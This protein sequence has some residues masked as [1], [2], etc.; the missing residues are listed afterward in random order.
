MTKNA[1]SFSPRLSSLPMFLTVTVGFILACTLS[2]VAAERASGDRPN[3]LW[4]TCE[5][6]SPHLGCYGAP[7]AITPHLDRLAQQGTRYTHAFSISGVCAPSRSCI[8]TGMY[9]TSIGSQ[10]MRCRA[11]LPKTIR[12]FTEYLREAGYYCT[13][14]RKTDYNFAHPKSAWDESSNTAHWRNRGAGQPF[15]SVF[16]MTVTHESRVRADDDQHAKNTTSLTASQRQDPSKLTLPPYYPVTPKV[17]KDWAHYFE[18]ITAMDHQAGE[19]LD[20]LENDGFAENT[21]VFYYSDHG[22]GL[23]RAKRWLYDSG[24]H[25]PMIVRWPGH[26]EAAAVE[27]RLVSFVDLAPT[28][29]SIAGI[30]IPEHLQGL[31][32]LGP[33]AGKPRRY[34]YAAR[35]RMDERYD[36]IRAVR[37]H[38]YKY[39]RNYQ[40]FKTRAQ[41]LAYAEVGSTM[42]ELRRLHQQ[43]EL[44]AVQQIFMRPTKPVEE[45]YDLQADPHEIVNLAGS[46]EH[47]EVI[48]R[49]RA[50]HESWMDRTLDTGLLPETE[51]ERLAGS[52]GIYA[53]VR[54]EKTAFPVRKLRDAALFA[55][56][57]QKTISA[58]S[59]ALHDEDPTI[60]YW[61]VTGMSTLERLDRHGREALNRVLKDDSPSV[62][63]VAAGALYRLGEREPA[64][65]VL[66]DAI[67]DERVCVRVLAANVIDG[68]IT[69]AGAT[70]LGKT[71]QTELARAAEDDDRNVKKLVS[72]TL[73]VL[74]DSTGSSN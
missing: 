1:C 46:R 69:D 12:C 11:V 70:E 67:G 71:L 24:L 7:R 19:I 50:E 58:L 66:R 9:P 40:P 47:R 22:V 16:N 21:I 27:D 59:E 38:R 65:D 32:F 26:V 54:D 28:V 68:L 53:V 30:D 48:E 61:A 72:H 52:E 20:Q 60:R 41:Y 23:P 31:P 25:V 15:F 43:G 17:R 13:N 8:I 3:I 62:G 44:D 34:I 64:I 56:G 73:G 74:K 33:K 39:I 49:L 36:L 5:D 57:D 37:D 18:L 63:I 6:I 55:I 29:L 45:L 42:Q 14:N 2:A 4:L 51:L 35:D 10:H